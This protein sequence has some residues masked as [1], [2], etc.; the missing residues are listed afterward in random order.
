MSLQKLMQETEYPPERP[1]LLQ[2]STLKVVMIVDAVSPTPFSLLRR[3]NHF[4]YR[5]EDRALQE[6]AD[7]EDPVKALTDECRRVLKSISSANQSQI[8]TSKESTGL[9]DASWSRFEDIGFS[10]GFDEND[11]EDDESNFMK[12]RAPQG[13]RSTPHSKNAGMG[14]PTTPSWADFLSAGFIDEAEN[15]PRPL[16]L[17]PV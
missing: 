17:P 15:G 2:S 1:S 9:T 4:Q 11:D 8:S 7:Y 6:F 3:A 14:R 13:L 5:D 12:K 10:A 16:L